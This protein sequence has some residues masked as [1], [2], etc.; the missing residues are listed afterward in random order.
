M[1]AQGRRQNRPRRTPQSQLRFRI[2]PV[3]RQEFDQEAF[4]RVCLLLAMHLDDVD[5][6]Q[7]TSRDDGM[8][9]GIDNGSAE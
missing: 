3:W 6:Q 7:S 8:E 4:A 1:T 9:G 5:R 2:R